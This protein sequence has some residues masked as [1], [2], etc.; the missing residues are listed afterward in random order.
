MPLVE[1]GQRLSYSPQRVEEEMES[2]LISKEAR[3]IASDDETQPPDSLHVFKCN[4]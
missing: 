3:P 4:V 1:V 2:A